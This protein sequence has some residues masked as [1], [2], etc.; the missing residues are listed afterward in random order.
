M[1]NLAKVW[2]WL[3]RQVCMVR[4]FIHELLKALCVDLDCFFKCWTFI[5][6]LNLS[7]FSYF[8]A[9]NRDWISLE[10]C[11][12]GLI[13]SCYACIVINKYTVYG[14]QTSLEIES[15]IGKGD[16]VMQPISIS[17]ASW[18]SMIDGSSA[19]DERLLEKLLLTVPWNFVL[20]LLKSQ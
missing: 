20:T 14:N 9:S 8:Q 4:M 15:W 2:T 12:A 3:V 17:F 1:T 7:G 5:K 10:T 16:L 13:L 6:H 19:A 11:F 18:L